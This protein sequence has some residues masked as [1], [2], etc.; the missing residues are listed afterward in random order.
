MYNF[1]GFNSNTRHTIR[2]YT[3]EKFWFE[4][5]KMVR[6][7][8]LFLSTKYRSVKNFLI[9]K[10]RNF[11]ADTKHQIGLTSVFTLT[12]A[13]F[14]GTL[15]MASF[16]DPSIKNF[17]NANYED[18]SLACTLTDY[19]MFACMLRLSIR[20]FRESNVGIRDPRDDHIHVVADRR[21]RNEDPRKRAKRK[22]KAATLKV[23][24]FNLKMLAFIEFCLAFAFG[25]GGL[26]HH[27][28]YDKNSSKNQ[29]CWFLINRFLA[30]IFV[31]CFSSPFMYFCD[32]T[33]GIRLNVYKAA[34]FFG[35]LIW[36]LV[37]YKLATAGILKNS[38]S[39]A[40]SCVVSFLVAIRGYYGDATFYIR[41]NKGKMIPKRKLFLCQVP[42]ITYMV[43][44]L[45]FGETTC[46]Q[47]D[48]YSKGCPFP[49]GFNHNA[50]LHLVCLVTFW[51]EHS[52]F[53]DF[54]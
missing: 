43:I 25:I 39:F 24:R 44:Y 35:T 32:L 48:G 37:E 5:Q 30:M 47:P 11:A 31:S 19:L 40:I 52:C 13:Y 21:T 53:V 12:C 6:F 49:D 22:Q 9:Y 45:L 29:F 18:T 42:R 2:P 33:V 17:E 26:T 8:R 3:G 38:D 27:F 46:N 4:V 50:C 41:T 34:V 7:L 14:Y 1:N 28:Y 10:P 54:D 20:T 16:F 51:L 15:V 36:L 23:A